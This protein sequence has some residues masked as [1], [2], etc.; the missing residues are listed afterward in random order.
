MLEKQTIVV[1]LHDGSA[2]VIDIVMSERSKSGDIV[3]QRSGSIEDAITETNL[4][5]ASWMN[6]EHSQLPDVAFQ[7]AWVVDGGRVVVDMGKA[8]DIHRAKIRRARA[9]ILAELDIAYQR[10]DEVGRHDIKS[11]LAAR[12]AALR[13]CTDDPLI[14]AATTPEQ[15]KKV[16]PIS[17]R[18]VAKPAAE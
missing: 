9:P 10:A 2:V 17:L 14:E 15:L 7:S 3:W 11:D 13:D 8:R 5:V 6:I 18:A 16:W 12:K 1:S 4:D